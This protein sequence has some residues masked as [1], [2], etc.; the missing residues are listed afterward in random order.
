M[1]AFRMILNVR[2][3]FFIF[4]FAKIAES[5][6]LYV[7]AFFVASIFDKKCSET[8]VRINRNRDFI[9]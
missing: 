3:G 9:L 5:V 8:S 2:V 1:R 6:L 7:E 4:P